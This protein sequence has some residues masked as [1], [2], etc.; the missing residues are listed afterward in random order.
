MTLFIRITS[1][2]AYLAA[3]VGAVAF[4]AYL[5]TL[6]PSVDFIDSGELATDCYTLGICHPTGYPLFTLIGWV[7]SHLPIASLPILRLNIMAAFF[8]AAGAG[9]LVLVANEV[10]S[11]W[12]PERR[13]QSKAGKLP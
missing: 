7:F 10:F 3:L 13:K 8:T 9:M 11:F 5:F 6:A 12:M 2:P 4:V 1:R